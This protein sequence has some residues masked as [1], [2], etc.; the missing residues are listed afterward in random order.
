[1][2][3]DLLIDHGEFTGHLAALQHAGKQ[4]LAQAYLFEHRDWFFGEAW[5]AI[6]SGAIELEWAH[7]FVR[8][9][10]VSV[11]KVSPVQLRALLRGPASRF[12][13]SLTLIEVTAEAMQVLVEWPHNPV[14]QLEWLSPSSPG[15]SLP[16]P[17]WAALQVF[18]AEQHAFEQATSCSLRT[19]IARR[20]ED[21][22]PYDL[23]ALQALT[24][25]SG[26]LALPRVLRTSPRLKRLRTGIEFDTAAVI[27]EV[28]S[29]AP[30]LE[31]LEV[32]SLSDTEARDLL[33]A[34]PRLSKLS[35]VNPGR[36]HGDPAVLEA[37]RLA[38][39]T[40]A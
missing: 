17:S 1:M 14:V 36:F 22:G 4:H 8:S 12:L 40:R 28:L 38:L 6:A 34:L 39:A 23:P 29:Q 19:L 32:D 35:R 30:Q 37:L 16:L 5:P 31:S 3:R 15:L 11:A 9:A 26:S 20:L 13:E 24:V 18:A 21:S 25:E 2:Y 7:G 27:R 33:D 10:G